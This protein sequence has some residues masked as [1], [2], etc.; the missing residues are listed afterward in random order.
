MKCSAV[1]TVG[2]DRAILKGM[3]P[4]DKDIG[5]ARYTI[6]KKGEKIVFAINADDAAS[7]RAAFNSVTKMLVVAERMR[8]VE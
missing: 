2:H 1:I 7:L 3:A 5:R 6:R 8:E 4:E